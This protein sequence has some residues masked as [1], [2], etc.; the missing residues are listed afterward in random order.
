MDDG[1]S[2]F[3]LWRITRMDEWDQEFVDAEVEGY[4]R[5]D[6]DGSGEFQFGYVHGDMNCELTQRRGRAV[7]E[8]S[9][10]GNDE[11]ERASGRGWA[12]V[13]K[14]GTLAG[15]LFFHSG[16]KSGFTA[17]RKGD[18]PPRQ[19]RCKGMRIMPQS[20]PPEADGP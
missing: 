13:Q 5:F 2:V 11:M 10:V 15:K 19:A 9:W 18:V 4:F 7:V 20:K 3:G 14:D 17:V 8:W 12:T 6:H 1:D 16:D